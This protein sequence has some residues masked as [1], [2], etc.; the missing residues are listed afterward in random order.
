MV[1][2]DNGYARYHLHKRWE[3]LGSDGWLEV[4]PPWR[5]TAESSNGLAETAG[6]VAGAHVQ[7]M[8]ARNGEKERESPVY[9]GKLWFRA[10]SNSFETQN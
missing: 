7:I 4:M 5:F 8:L 9:N 10:S 2:E 3:Y 1:V 6:Y